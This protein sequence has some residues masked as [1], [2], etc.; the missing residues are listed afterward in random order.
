MHLVACLISPWSRALSLSSTGVLLD[1]YCGFYLDRG[2]PASYSHHA[3]E[4]RVE[5]LFRIQCFWL[6][7]C[8]SGC[9]L[10]RGRGWHVTLDN[11]ALR[12]PI[13]PLCAYTHPRTQ[14]S[15]IP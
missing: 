10:L 3:A 1:V 4:R 15:T 8:I 11:R 13:E 14:C 6:A 9:A 2:V 5:S 12:V 7:V